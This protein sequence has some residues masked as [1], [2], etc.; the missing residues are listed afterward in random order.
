M[1]ASTVCPGPP[2]HQADSY[3]IRY[4]LLEQVAGRAVDWTRISITQHQITE[5]GLTPI[6]KKVHRYRPALEHEAWEAEALGQ[7]TIERLVRDALDRLPPEPL[8]VVLEQE[9]RERERLEG[10]AARSW[11]TW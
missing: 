7:E 9:E 1:A 6:W 11:P 10:I 2:G 4:R 5:R 3:L 8:A